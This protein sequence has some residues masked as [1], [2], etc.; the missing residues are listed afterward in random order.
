MALVRAR[1]SP[2]CISCI[3]IFSMLVITT[4]NIVPPDGCFPILILYLVL[5]LSMRESPGTP[6]VSIILATYN[7]A[8][9]LEEQL[10]SIFA[11]TYPNFEVIAVDDGSTDRTVGILRA[12]A[13]RHP[14]IMKVF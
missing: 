2:A 14:E 10:D 4:P 11:Q 12:Y 13:V 5:Y 9:Y 3:R 7:G 6:L 1:R 8:T